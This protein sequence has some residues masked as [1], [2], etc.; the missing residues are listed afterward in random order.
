M[1]RVWEIQHNGRP[2]R[3]IFVLYF[4][5]FI[6]L[7]GSTGNSVP[8]YIPVGWSSG[9]EFGQFIVIGGQS[10]PTA[11]RRNAVDVTFI[12]EMKDCTL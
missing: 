8:S 1:G 2:I 4:I 12:C 7:L 3:N 5:V 6:L 9:I 10:V 11:S